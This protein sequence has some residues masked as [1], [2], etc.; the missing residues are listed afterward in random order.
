M[1]LMAQPALAGYEEL[2]SPRLIA[3]YSVGTSVNDLQ[4]AL[5]GYDDC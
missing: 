3:S 5:A 4:P 2:G 1:K